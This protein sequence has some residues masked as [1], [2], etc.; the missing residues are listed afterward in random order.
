M[1]GVNGSMAKPQRYPLDT[2]RKLGAHKTFR[3]YPKHLLIY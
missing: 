1:E 3:R 2:G